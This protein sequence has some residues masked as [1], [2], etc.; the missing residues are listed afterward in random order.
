MIGVSMISPEGFAMR[1]LMP[2]SCRICC[3]FPLAPEWAIIYMGFRLFWYSYL[4]VAVGCRSLPVS[5]LAISGEAVRQHGGTS[6]SRTQLSHELV[7]NPLGH[8][9]PDI[10]YLVVPF[11]VRD[12]TF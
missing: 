11:T 1:P 10:D 12:E 9:G 3:A 7:G 6:P 8:V 2:A 5:R 4:G